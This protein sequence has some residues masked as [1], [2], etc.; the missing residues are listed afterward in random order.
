MKLAL[1]VPVLNQHDLAQTAIDF[2]LENLSGNNLVQIIVLDN[3]SDVPFLYHGV[4]LEINP[5]SLKNSL[6][7]YAIGN[8]SKTKLM[9]RQII[10]SKR[11]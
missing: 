5:K 10:L 7:L 3:G 11:R 9:I 4:N 2:A 1:I 6:A 8:Y